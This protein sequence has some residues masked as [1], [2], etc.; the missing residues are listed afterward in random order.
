MAGFARV[1]RQAVCARAVPRIIHQRR[2]KWEKQPAEGETRGQVPSRWPSERKQAYR[3]EC[4]LFQVVALVL[5][6]EKEEG[7]GSCAG[8]GEV[9]EM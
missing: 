1:C 8:R 3:E 2:L 7:G 9:P 6:K 5:A 4:V